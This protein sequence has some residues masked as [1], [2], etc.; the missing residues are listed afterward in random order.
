MKAEIRKFQEFEAYEEVDDEG[1]SS[2][3]IRWV[4]TKN[5]DSGKNQPI[6]ARLCIRGDLEKNKAEVRSDSPTIAKE[7]L[8]M[9]IF[10][11]ANE[12]F[13]VKSVDIK[14]AYLQGNE[15][16]RKIFV[17]PPS[18]AET[19]KLWLLKKAAYGILDGGR[20]FYLRL[21]ERLKEL[22][23]HK[24]NTEGALFTYVKNGKL[25]GIVVSHV[26]DLL[27]AGDEEFKMDIES[28]LKIYF[29]LSKIET[30]SFNY[31]GCRIIMLK[32]GDI[33]LDQNEYADKIKMIEFDE[34]DDKRELR[35]EEQKI[36]RGKIGEILWISLMTRPDLSFEVNRMATEVP[37]ATVKNFKEMNQLIKRVQ[38]RRKVLNFSKLG[39]L[40]ELRVKLYTDASYNNLNDKIH[41]TE[42]RV[43]MV[44]NKNTEKLCVISWKTKK[45]PRICRSVKSAE[46]RTLDD[47]GIDDAVHTAVD[48]LVTL[49]DFNF[50]AYKACLPPLSV[51]MLRYALNPCLM[52]GFY[53]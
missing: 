51:G 4:V 53:V 2:I 36:L 38:S 6:K 13:D 42:G 40:E 10:V 48:D 1:Q 46:T 21:E 3:P 22:G 8:K 12:G 41:S 30:G 45:I 52:L 31:C 14:S 26:D 11:A 29:K 7:T 16:E 37:K 39:S 35:P 49:E 9:A 20:L 25:H 15:L 28:K 32:N 27:L 19:E 43:L 17:K 44:E 33:Q 47:D 23:M 24:V 34:D 50:N 5:P 18:E